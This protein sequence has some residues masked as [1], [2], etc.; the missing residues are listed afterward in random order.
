MAS[1]GGNLLET[2]IACSFGGSIKDKL[3]ILMLGMHFDHL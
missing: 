3:G 1:L 2:N